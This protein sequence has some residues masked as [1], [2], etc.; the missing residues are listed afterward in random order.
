MIL[1]QAQAL[2]QAQTQAQTQAQPDDQAKHTIWNT[3]F[4]EGAV[5]WLLFIFFGIA[6]FFAIRWLIKQRHLYVKRM[7]PIRLFYAFASEIGL[8]HNQAK[9]LQ[10]IAK[11]VELTSPFTL[12]LSPRTLEHFTKMYLNQLSS[13]QSEKVRS[14]INQIKHSLFDTA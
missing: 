10:L 4:G 2:A 11:R 5:S 7:Q 6:L 12:I 13:K 3:N 14:E 9:Q 1:A 8:S